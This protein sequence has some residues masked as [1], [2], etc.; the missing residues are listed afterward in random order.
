MTAIQLITFDKDTESFCGV[1]AEH[2]GARRPC[3][4]ILELAENKGT[5][6]NEAFLQ[7]CQALRD[8]FYPHLGMD[9][10]D[11]T[12]TNGICHSDM[13][14]E[15]QNGI[16]TKIDLNGT[17][18]GG[19]NFK[20]PLKFYNDALASPDGFEHALTSG[21][22][23]IRGGVSAVYPVPVAGVPNNTLYFKPNQYDGMTTILVDAKKFVS[24]WRDQEETYIR[25]HSALQAHDGSRKNVLTRLF[26]RAHDNAQQADPD[27]D[28]RI[29]DFKLFESTKSRSREEI[30]KNTS[31][32]HPMPTAFLNFDPADPN[33]AIAF[34]N[35]RHRVFNAANLGAPYIAME[36]SG[37]VESF[38]ERFEYAAPEIKS[39]PLPHPVERHAAMAR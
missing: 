38:R 36:I 11:W 1:V 22:G 37:N 3:L 34:T 24:A 4:H 29:Q 28:G 27:L 20:L 25:K 31:P 18:L 19:R 26:T 33:G 13:S 8:H 9:Q 5:P 6:L 2:H 32:E 7:G 30:W 17:H 14:F 35:G 39:A 21:H 12:Y 16:V 15:Q 23:F 10:I